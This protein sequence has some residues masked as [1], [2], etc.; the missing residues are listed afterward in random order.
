MENYVA[1]KVAMFEVY[2]NDM[3]EEDIVAF[4]ENQWEYLKAGIRDVRIS[5]AACIA[6]TKC[7]G[8]V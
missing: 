4:S 1:F 7:G 2:K 3:S 8:T 5:D 6:W